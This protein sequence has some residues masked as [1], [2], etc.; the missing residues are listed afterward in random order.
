[1]I[2]EQFA[3]ALFS[4]FGPSQV[5]LFEQFA[6]ALF[7][8]KITAEMQCANDVAVDTEGNVYVTNCRANFLWKVTKDGNPSVFVKNAEFTSQPIIVDIPIGVIC[9]LNGIVFHKNGYLLVSQTNSGALFRVTLNPKTVHLVTME[10]KLPLA[11]GMA[12]RGDGTLVVV[13]MAKAWLLRTTS[14]WMTA[15]IL[16]T[17]LLNSSDFITSVTVKRDSLYVLP[18]FLSETSPRDTFELHEI[19]FPTEASDDDPLWLIGLLI[20]A[21]LV[22]AMWRLQMGNFYTQFKRKRA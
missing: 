11:D 2:F 8:V 6:A 10:G 20:L 19:V 5:Q 13:S 9:G 21:V 16:D 1:M 22:V 15:E 12:L 4:T 17:V 14:D 7:D 3:G 18:S